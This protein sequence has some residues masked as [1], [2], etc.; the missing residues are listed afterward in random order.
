MTWDK[1]FT[2]LVVALP[3][4]VGLCWAV[5]RNTRTGWA[6]TIVCSAGLGIVVFAMLIVV[7]AQYQ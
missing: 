3:L 6:T 5:G 1:A 4:V 2:L 7:R